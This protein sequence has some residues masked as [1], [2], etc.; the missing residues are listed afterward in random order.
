MFRRQ[1]AKRAEG[2]TEPGDIKN[3]AFA[4][5]VTHELTQSA[6]AQLKKHP[7]WMGE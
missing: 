3:L 4:H 7:N 1:I 6:F 2:T 5:K